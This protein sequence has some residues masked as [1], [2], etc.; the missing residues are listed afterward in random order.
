M[1]Q[2]ELMVL[3]DPELDERKF[4]R[5]LREEHAARLATVLKS[6]RTPIEQGATR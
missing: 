3:L 5:R 6:A 1:R 2:Y 4:L